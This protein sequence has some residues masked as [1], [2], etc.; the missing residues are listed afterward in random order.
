MNAMTPIA[1]THFAATHSLRRDR[2]LQVQ[3]P[4]IE[5][6]ASRDEQRASAALQAQ[7]REVREHSYLAAPTSRFRIC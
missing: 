7:L 5:R 2:R 6:R 3:V 1:T 4:R